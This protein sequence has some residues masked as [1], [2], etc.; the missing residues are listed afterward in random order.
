MF[1]NNQISV[2]FRKLHPNQGTLETIQSELE[3]FQARLPKKSVLKVDFTAQSDFVHATLKIFSPA[4]ELFTS[5]TSQSITQ[6][7]HELI[8]HVG[9]KVQRIKTRRR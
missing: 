4:G 8:R 7:C 5:A 1:S 3:R 9:R 6:A 2:R